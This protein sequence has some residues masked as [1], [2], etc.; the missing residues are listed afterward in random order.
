MWSDHVGP[1]DFRFS[2]ER[3]GAPSE[4]CEW[5]NGMIQLR[6]EEDHLAVVLKIDD[7]KN[8]S[9]LWLTCEEAIG[10]DA[11]QGLN[12]QGGS[13]GSDPGHSIKVQSKGFTDGVDKKCG[14][15]GEMRNRP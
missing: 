9:R 14:G 11:S 8:K 12:S 1:W 10:G 13:K 2:S 6:F 15:G 4:C 5:H 7:R 3:E